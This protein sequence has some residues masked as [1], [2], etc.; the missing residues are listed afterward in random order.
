MLPPTVA[1]LR[2][3]P[4]APARIARASAGKRCR[5]A[6][7]AATSV[8]VT[9]APIMRLPSARGSI[10]RDRPVTSTRAAGR[11]TVSRIRSTRLVPPPRKRAPDVSPASLMAPGTSSART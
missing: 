1:M 3:C 9:P 6:R 5:A 10:W 8:F 2:I 7:S 4:L 11:S